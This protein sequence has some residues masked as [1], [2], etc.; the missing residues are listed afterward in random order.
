MQRMRSYKAHSGICLKDKEKTMEYVKKLLQETDYL[1]QLKVL[2]EL[3]AERRFCRHGLNH[4]LDVARIAWIQMLEKG[5]A[6]EKE[7]VY[8]TALLHD[9]GRV[10][11][12]QEG[13]P[14]HEAGIEIAEEY[15]S[16]IGY[17]R[18]KCNLILEAIG[19]HREKEKLNDDFT[20]IIK[21]A[22]TISR[23]CFFC[24]VTKECKW[25]R[26]RKNTTIIR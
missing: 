14:H 13:T 25:S 7:T 4:V 2:E 23:N 24:E 21:E 9:M 5:M 16:Q 8:L 17:S 10:R 15:L 11:E 6:Y 22:D 12:Y 3:E 20:N 18:E 19:Q 26:E 1:Q